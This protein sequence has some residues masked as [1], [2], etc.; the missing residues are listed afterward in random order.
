MSYHQLSQA[1][2][3]IIAFC[4]KRGVAKA[5]LAQMIGRHPSTIYRE[6]ERNKTH[7][8]GWYRAWIADGYAIA[9]R[10]RE[11]RGTHFSPEEWGMV[12]ALLERKLSPEQ[13]A[14]TL[15][16][17]HKL[18][19][20]HE[21][22]YQYIYDDRQHGGMLFRNLR[23][24]KRKHGKRG[25]KQKRRDIYADRRKINERP[26]YVERRS[27]VGDWEGDTVYGADRRHSIVTL[28]ERRTGYAVIKKISARTIAEVNRVILEAISEHPW[29]FR[30][31][32]F[33]NGFEFM[34][35]RELEQRA[36][37]KCYFANPYHSWERGTNE[38][39]NG[40]VR[41]YLPKRSCMRH[42]AQ[43]DCDWIAE[44]LNCRPRKRHGYRTPKELFYEY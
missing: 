9:R 2:R 30:S 22:I 35:F 42:V 25:R 12:I 38:N 31:I 36:T 14:G 1:E 44:E 10:R 13:I 39:L 24:K 21:T 40:L 7:H 8:D 18:S 15:K 5:E 41:Q 23:T 20:S 6:V 33:D 34:G 3:Y 37:I 11:R 27:Q 26:Q 43:K 28:V 29:R 4:L 19:I 32:T 16:V 17:E